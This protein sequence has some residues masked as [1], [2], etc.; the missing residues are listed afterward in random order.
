[1]RKQLIIWLFEKSLNFYIKYFKQ[2]QQAW[3]F[4]KDELLSFHK[5]TFGYHLGL[6]LK[7]NNFEIIPKVERHDCYHVLTGYGTKVEDEITLQYLCFGNGKRSIYLFG[8]II[9]GSFLLPEYYKYYLQSFKRGRNSAPFYNL[10]YRELL[11]ENIGKL[12][13]LTFINLRYA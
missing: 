2:K 1:M 4:S 8:V 12:R 11:T 3:N 6:F 5:N 10:N 9:L 7:T 13:A